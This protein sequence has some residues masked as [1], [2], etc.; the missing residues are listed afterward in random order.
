MS[1]I[2]FS[3]NLTDTGY[4][5][6]TIEEGPGIRRVSFQRLVPLVTLCWSCVNIKLYHHVQK[7]SEHLSW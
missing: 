1:I 5:I 7:R 3:G 6:D 2:F 4:A